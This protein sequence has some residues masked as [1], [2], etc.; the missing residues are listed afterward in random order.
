MRARKRKPASIVNPI[1]TVE[2]GQ[3]DKQVKSDPPLRLAPPHPALA[4]SAHFARL[5][6]GLRISAFMSPD[7]HNASIA[8]RYGRYKPDDRRT[9]PLDRDEVLRLYGEEAAIRLFPHP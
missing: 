9:W 1:A 2:R 5:R 6:A 4:S 7:E 8:A 3:I